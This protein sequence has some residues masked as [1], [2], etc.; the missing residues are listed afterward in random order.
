[1]RNYTEITQLFETALQNEI[2][3]ISR[4]QPSNLYD[5]VIYTLNMGGKR[6]RP[7]LLTMAYEMFDKQIERAFPAAMA[8]EMFHNFTLLHDDMMDGASMRRNKETIHIKYSNNTAIL[9]GDAMSI[10]SYDYINRCDTQHFREV[11]EIF[12]N[13]AL[14]ICEGQQ[15]DMDFETRND[16]TVDEYLHMIGLKTAILLAASLKIGA[17]L[18]NAPKT[19]AQLLYDFGFNL[20]MAFQLQDDFL[21]TYGDS[22]TFGKKIGGDIVANKKT[23]LMLKTLELAKGD[24]LNELNKLITDEA[25]DI[26]KKVDSVT[27]I[28]NQVD[29]VS[30]SKE[31][32][33][34][35]YNKAIA[36]F[37]KVNLEDEKKSELLLVAQKMLKRTK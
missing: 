27:A 13:T 16:V 31:I 35:Y 29:V 19:D 3:R 22:E 1:M 10:I 8:I 4:L 36:C 34:D 11:I 21:D 25:I 18:A 9:S 15:Y 7:A 33:E 24:Q 5:P 28:Y 17:L 2:E 30:H 37:D 14:K 26:Q 6:I 20:G 12:T 32:M 23:F